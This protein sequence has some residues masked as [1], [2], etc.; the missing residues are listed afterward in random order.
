MHQWNWHDFEK[1][2]SSD[3][4]DPHDPYQAFTQNETDEYVLREFWVGSRVDGFL[5]SIGFNR[6][7]QESHLRLFVGDAEHDGKMISIP[8]SAAWIVTFSLANSENFDHVKLNFRQK[9]DLIIGVA[10]A[11]YDHYNVSKSGLYLWKAARPE[12]NRVYNKALGLARETPFKF[13]SIPLTK[14]FNELGDAGRG[15]AIITQYY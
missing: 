2:E 11:L 1:E 9:K 3:E 6:V 5:Y 13:K 7:S 8:E 10:S 12:L 4:P 14:N 15:Y